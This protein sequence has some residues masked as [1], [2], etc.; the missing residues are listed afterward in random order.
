MKLVSYLKEE[1]EQLAL[2]VEGMIRSS[3]KVII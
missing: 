3:F 2:F 1:H